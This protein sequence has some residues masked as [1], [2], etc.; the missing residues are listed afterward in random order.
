MGHGLRVYLAD[1]QHR[2]ST[3]LAQPLVSPTGRYLLQYFLQVVVTSKCL[4]IAQPLPKLRGHVR[5]S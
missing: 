4:V 3:K 2:T 1:P 5:K